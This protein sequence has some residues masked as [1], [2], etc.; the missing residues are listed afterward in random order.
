MIGYLS[1]N[2]KYIDNYKTAIDELRYSPL[3]DEDIEIL[4]KKHS[5]TTKKLYYWGYVTSA[6]SSAPE[7]PQLFVA[8]SSDPYSSFGF[9][10]GLQWE[11]FFY[12]DGTTYEGTMCENFPHGKGALSIGYVGGG[13]LLTGA[14]SEET[15]FGD[16]YEGEFNNGFVHGMGKYLNRDGFVF[17]GE[18]MAGMKHGCGEIKDFS[19]YLELVQNGMN[20][21]RAWQVDANKSGKS[22]LQGTWL[23]DYFSEGP[24]EN[25]SGS[26]CTPAEIS[27]VVEES[28]EIANKARMFRYK[29][30]GM[31]RVFYQESSGIPIKTLQGPVHYPYDT[32]FLAP[33]PVSQLVPLP[34]DTMCDAIKNEMIRA[35]NL[36]RTIYSEYNIDTDLEPDDSFSYAFDLWT[37]RNTTFLNE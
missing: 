27:G 28:E 32:L 31:V 21:V 7:D 33:G 29:P 10:R 18:F 16:L 17:T 8:G 22:I 36:W 13:G 14:T 1:D 15:Q 20:P 6:E 23:N 25:Y 11:S 4:E 2:T 3:T 34:C 19:S 5:D 12:D 24:D 30:D 35:Q 26:A 37:D 9:N